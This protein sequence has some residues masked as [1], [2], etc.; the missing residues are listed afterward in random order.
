MPNNLLFVRLHYIIIIYYLL[1]QLVT[2]NNVWIDDLLT[3]LVTDNNVWMDDLLTQL[4]T[5]NNVGMDDLL[6]QLVTDN[7]VQ[8]W[9]DLTLLISIFSTNKK[10]A[11]KNRRVLIVD[12]ISAI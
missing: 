12:T 5:D 1:T 8:G 3:Q 7:N 4:V 6:T 9:M 10:T 11:R 2:D